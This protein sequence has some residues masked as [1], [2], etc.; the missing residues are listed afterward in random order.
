MNILTLI[1]PRRSAQP[2]E[3]P[4]TNWA[5]TQTTDFYQDHVG[6][7]ILTNEYG[8]GMGSKIQI[9]SYKFY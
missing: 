4:S 8:L 7:I 9:N 3:D 5:Q 6:F 1:L 2:R